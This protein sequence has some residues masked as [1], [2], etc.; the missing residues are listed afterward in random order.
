MTHD[1]LPAATAPALIGLDW[2]TTSLRA[3][4]LATDGAV[5]ERRAEA[6]GIMRLPDGGFPAAFAGVTRGWRD[7]HPRLPAVAAGMVGSAQGWVPA[8][9]CPAPAGAD[10]LA[11]RLTE[12][13]R[14]ALHVI[15]GVSRFDADPPDVM[16][17][18]E[19]QVVGALGLHPELW[20]DSTLVLPGTHSKWVRVSN[21]RMWDLVTYLTGELFAV[22]RQHSILGR[23]AAESSTDRPASADASDE[24][25]V[26]GVRAARDSAR[27]LA[28]LLFSTRALVLAGRLEPESSLDYLSGLL[29]G[30]EL[31]CEL[32]EHGSRLALIGEEALCARYVTALREFGVEDAPVVDGAAPAGLWSIARHAGLVVQT[33]SI[34]RT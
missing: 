3:Y 11:A 23:P 25:F 26:R 6:W 2:G 10:E 18:E 8:P 7:A 14:A 16:R 9:Y 28:P 15:P 27:G 22:L 31:R 17:G 32:R 21:G 1:H 4:L 5:I 33:P 19:T 12:I 24:A 34:V 20:H 13:P 30:E 29:V